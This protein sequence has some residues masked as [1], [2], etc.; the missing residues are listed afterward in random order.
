MVSEDKKVP[1]F[2]PISN[3][4]KPSLPAQETL[5]LFYAKFLALF[6]STE[7]TPF[8]A[9]DK[10]KKATL[11]ILDE[12]VA[13]PA[14]G[15]VIDE[16]QATLGPW[17]DEKSS[18]FH[19]ASIVLP[20]CDENGILEEWA[21]RNGHQILSA[22]ARNALLTPVEEP[23]LPDLSGDGVLVIPRLEHWFLRHQDGLKTIRRLLAAINTLDRRVVIGCNSWAWEFLAKA[24]GADMVLPEGKT[25][26]AFDEMRLYRW[27]SELSEDEKSRNLSFKLPASGTD[28]MGL[29]PEGNLA[30]DFFKTLAARSLGIPWVA[31][32]MWRRSLR[33]GDDESIAA[34]T[35]AGSVDQEAAADEQTLWV[36]ALEEFVLPGGGDPT[37]LLAL[38]ALVIHGTLTVEELRLVLPTVGESNVLSALITAGFVEREKEFLKCRPAAYPAIRQGLSSAGFSMDRL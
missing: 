14:C 38:H 21:L 10:L 13:P 35:E 28:V 11:D 24:V 31:W 9:D 34:E 30:N 16:L 23:L 4:T 1:L 22:A 37:A 12:V 2:E 33:S 3:F 32:H 27:M 7:T 36:A 15:P 5:R 20:P 25:F 8:I 17:I 26:K 29:D 6:H 18:P 19:I